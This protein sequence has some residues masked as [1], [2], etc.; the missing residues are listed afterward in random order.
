MAYTQLASPLA[1]QTGPSPSMQEVGP[2]AVHSDM[3]VTVQYRYPTALH[4]HM[5]VP[6]NSLQQPPPTAP[7]AGHLY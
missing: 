3:S 7:T 4:M 1:V 2:H 5:T 6:T